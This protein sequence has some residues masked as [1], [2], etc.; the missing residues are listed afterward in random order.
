M[1]FE[2]EIAIHWPH[3]RLA[4]GW[5]IVRPD[6]LYDYYTFRLYLFVLTITL[7]IQ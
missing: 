3:D 7:N 2:L 6:D 4:L 5:D 1:N